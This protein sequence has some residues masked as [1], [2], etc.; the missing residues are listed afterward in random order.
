MKSAATPFDMIEANLHSL[1]LRMADVPAPSILLCR[2]IMHI[3][4][5]MAA[6]FE[7]QIRPYGLTEAEFRVL[8]TL[9]SQP[10]GMAHPRDLC[11]RASQS[12][13]NM[14]RI[15]D[16]LVARDLITRAL[17]ERDRRRMVLRMTPPGEA[18]VRE[19]L[20]SLYGGLRDTFRDFTDAQQRDLTQQLRRLGAAFERVP[21][22]AAERHP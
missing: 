14:S 12:A 18:L 16:A 15:C 10:D 13:A 7:Q 6:R 2:V 20:P 22:E 5:E 8:T 17:S 19:L 3:A 4:R 21:V 9:Y 1:S 11:L